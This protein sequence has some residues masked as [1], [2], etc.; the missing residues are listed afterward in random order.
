MITQQTDDE[1]ARAQKLDEWR[2]DAANKAFDAHRKTIS[3]S[4]GMVGSFANTAMRAPAIAAG[5]GI[6]GLLGFF[7]ANK[8]TLV[9]SDATAYFNQALTLFC[10]SIALSVI[11]SGTAYVS[12]LLLTNSLAAHTFNYESPFVRET[13]TSKWWEWFGTAFQIMA[14]GLGLTAMALLV[15]GGWFFIQMANFLSVHAPLPPS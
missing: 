5:A 1:K 13:R 14:I 9:G 8:S 7:S 2:M 12:Q 4:F 10:G 6:A 3:D 15:A 11:C